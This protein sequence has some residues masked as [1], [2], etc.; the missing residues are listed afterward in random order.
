MVRCSVVAALLYCLLHALLPGSDRAV[1]SVASAALACVLLLE[2]ARCP[3]RVRVRCDSGTLWIDAVA[4]LR[5]RSLAVR[6]S[7]VRS[8]RLRDTALLPRHAYVV[9][10]LATGDETRIVLC[11]NW[12]LPEALH[13]VRALCEM[14]AFDGSRVHARLAQPYRGP[15]LAFDGR[16]RIPRR[17][18]LACVAI[19]AATVVWLVALTI[20]AAHFP[21]AWG[22]VAIAAFGG[23][24]A[25]GIISIV[26]ASTWWICMS[27][28]H[29]QRVEVSSDGVCI[30]S[31]GAW[32]GT[33]ATV[34]DWHDIVAAQVAAADEAIAPPEARELVL[35]L[36]SGRP[37][38]VMCGA[39]HEQID[40]C[41]AAISGGPVSPGHSTAPSEPD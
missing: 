36:Q 2:W 12:R 6:S 29:E 41:C 24:A 13:F 3:R 19:W 21:F 20:G 22:G 27:P 18:R 33:Q 1:A 14:G 34:L 28:Q 23:V 16:S 32:P 9:V 17:T 39:S 30:L 40:A 35:W 5:T 26:W 38:R 15:R 11:R 10:D 7:D 31:R 4:P 25:G 8:V 37:L